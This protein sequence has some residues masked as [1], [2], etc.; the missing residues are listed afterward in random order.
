MKALRPAFTKKHKSSYIEK[1]GK[2]VKT[3]ETVLSTRVD[4][5]PFLACHLNSYVNFF[6]T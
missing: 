4:V 6:I 2:A 3:R 1:R 5:H